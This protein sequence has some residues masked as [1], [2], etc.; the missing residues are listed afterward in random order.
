MAGYLGPSSPVPDETPF[1]RS[2]SWLRPT[3]DLEPADLL[4]RYPAA[5]DPS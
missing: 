3:I 5:A 2:T 4:G 1:E